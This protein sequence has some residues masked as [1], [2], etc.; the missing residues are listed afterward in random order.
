MSVVSGAMAIR[1]KDSKAVLSYGMLK[2]VRS[3]SSPTRG[4][5]LWGVLGFALS[6]V[7][8]SPA[9]AQQRP[10]LTED[11]EVVGAGRLLIEGGIDGA[12]EAHYPLSGLDGNLWRVPVVGISF[13]LS[14]IA[15]L[16]FDGGPYN[17]LSITKRRPAPLS[18]LVT[19]T[20]D[21]THDVEDLVVGT[22]VRVLAEAARHPSFA[23]RFATRL[24][25]AS[26]ESGLGLDTTDFFASLLGAKTVQSIRVVGNL[27]VGILADPMNGHEQNDVVTYGASVARAVTDQAEVVAEVNG[28]VSTRDVPFPGTETRGLLNLGARYTRGPIRFDGSVFFGLTS[29]D[30]TIGVS[31]G[32]TY[33]IHAFDVP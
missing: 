11:P 23:V 6:M 29:L 2:F 18:T 33:V 25:N 14:S 27:G 9:L 12:H 3:V 15:E 19:A 20:G 17:H 28:R 10:L 26:N 31:A 7:A 8:A 16:Q 13:G 1:L 24:P 5:I 21:G 4:A 22:K 30:P 32:F